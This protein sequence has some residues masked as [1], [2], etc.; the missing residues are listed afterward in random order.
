GVAT[1]FAAQFGSIS[2]EKGMPLNVYSQTFCD[3][4]SN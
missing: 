3:S 2:N 4:P 1:Q